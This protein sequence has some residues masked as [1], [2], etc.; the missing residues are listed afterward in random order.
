MPCTALGT[1]SAAPGTSLPPQTPACAA[2]GVVHRDIKLCNLLVFEHPSS[3]EL[4]E[5]SL[6]D[7]DGSCPLPEGAD[8]V[9]AW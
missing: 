7:W 1:V 5:V 9:G 2:S 3:G 6:I 8:T 4:L